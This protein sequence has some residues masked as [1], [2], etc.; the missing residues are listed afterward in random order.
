M[1][2][3]VGLWC[4]PGSWVAFGLCAAISGASRFEH[5]QKMFYLLALLV[6]VSFIVAIPVFIALLL[7]RPK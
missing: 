2:A 1:V 3:L 6:A 4:F 5:I 7:N